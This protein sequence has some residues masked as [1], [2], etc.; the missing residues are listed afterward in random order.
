MIVRSRMTRSQ[1]IQTTN[2]KTDENACRTTNFTF[3]MQFSH[4]LSRED[5][6][7]IPAKRR[8][9]AI[10]RYV[11]QLYNEIYNAAAA[12]K[13]SYLHKCVPNQSFGKTY[14]PQYIPTTED[15]IE[16]LKAKYPGCS[17]SYVEEWVDVR[18]GVKEQRSG[19]KIDWS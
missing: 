7:A 15:I 3:K 14:P 9:E 11:D 6:Q 2:F 17:V 5:L 10:T 8:I 12:G 13:S 16:G 19:I 18:P 1:M 4:T